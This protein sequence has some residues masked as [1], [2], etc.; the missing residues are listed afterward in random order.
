M[1]T[2]KSTGGIPEEENEVEEDDFDVDSAFDEIEEPISKP[3]DIYQLG[4]H[5]LM[6]GDSTNRDD[7]DK[8]MDGKKEQL[9]TLL[10]TTLNQQ[11][12]KINQI[13]TR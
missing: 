7:V 3:G 4:E 1:T 9:T 10:M 12:S 11:S 2:T 8:L 13:L 6:C 5:R